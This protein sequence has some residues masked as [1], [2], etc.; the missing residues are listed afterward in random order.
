MHVL[1]PSL[2][3][4]LRAVF[5][6]FLTRKGEGIK[7]DTKRLLT[8][9]ETIFSHFRAMNSTLCTGDVYK[10]YIEYAGLLYFLLHFQIEIGLELHI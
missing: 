2:N 1:S 6:H 7:E 5:K 9:F 8:S 4:L 3:L 10:L